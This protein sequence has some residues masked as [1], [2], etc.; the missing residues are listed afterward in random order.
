MPTLPNGYFKINEVVGCKSGVDVLL[1]VVV[2][3]STKLNSLFFVGRAGN[4]S[5]PLNVAVVNTPLVGAYD[6][7]TDDISANNTACL[8]NLY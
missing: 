8:F 6:K 7:F 4:T 2:M 5:C 3:L 1:L